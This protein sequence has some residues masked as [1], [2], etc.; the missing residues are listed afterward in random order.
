M[1]LAVFFLLVQYVDMKGAI[2]VF[3]AR[4]HFEPLI[5][6]KIINQCVEPN[7]GGTGMYNLLNFF[8]LLNLQ[9]TLR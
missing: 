1:W 5:Y 6:I 7:T 8:F 4:D 9:S 3:L 2:I